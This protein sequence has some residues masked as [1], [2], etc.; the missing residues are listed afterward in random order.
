MGL[1]LESANEMALAIGEEVSGSVKKFVELMNTRAQQLGCKN[2]HFN[3]PNGLPDETHV[4]TASDMAKIAKAAWLNPLCRK[5]F[6]TDLYE[7]P[8]T[9][10]FTETRY[11][12]NHHKMMSGRD[13]AYDG[14]LGGKTGY[15]TAAGNTLITFAKRGNMTLVAVV[16]NSVNGAYSDTAA[17]LDYGFDNF[18]C[19]KVKIS[20]NPV[21]KKNLPNEEYL[22]NNCGNT[23]PFYYTKNVYVTVPAGTDLSTLTKKQAILSNAVGPLRLKSKYYFNGQMVGWGMQYERSVM[24]DL[25]TIPGA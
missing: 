21:P 13:Y 23:Y 25:L 19:K 15:T 20:K 17:L 5:F 9:N 10:K 8:P 24:K 16:L 12:L 14:V 18:E 4:T 7:I 22:L 6:T 11:L 2:S 1:M 3:N